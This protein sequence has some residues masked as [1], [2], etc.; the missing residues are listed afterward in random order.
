MASQDNS[1][2]VSI[3]PQNKQRYVTLYPNDFETKS[4]LFSFIENQQVWVTN[5]IKGYTLEFETEK[6]DETG[7]YFLKVK[8]NCAEVLNKDQSNKGVMAY[9]VRLVNDSSGKVE[10]ENIYL[11]DPLTATGRENFYSMLNYISE[12]NDQICYDPSKS[13]IADIGSKKLHHYNYNKST[14]TMIAENQKNIISNLNNAIRNVGELVANLTKSK[15]V[16]KVNAKT[17]I[18]SALN[19]SYDYKDYSIR[20]NLSYDLDDYN[21][22]YAMLYISKKNLRQNIEKSN[23]YA[24]N[25]RSNIEKLKKEYEPEIPQWILEYEAEKNINL[26]VNAKTNEIL[27][28]IDLQLSHT[29]NVLNGL[30]SRPQMCFNPSKSFL[31]NKY[32]NQLFLNLY[33]PFIDTERRM[34]K[35]FRDVIS[36]PLFETS[37]IFEILILVKYIEALEDAGYVSTG[38]EFKDLEGTD[39]IN[40]V[41]FIFHKGSKK[42]LLT[43]NQKASKITNQNDGLI[44]IKV[45][46]NTPDFSLAVVDENDKVTYLMVADAKC[47]PFDDIILFPEDG[48]EGHNTLLDYQMFRYAINTNYLKAKAVDDLV[49]VCPEEDEE[50][51]HVD[52]VYGVTFVNTSLANKFD[53]FYRFL[54]EILMRE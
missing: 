15:R 36:S 4:S 13:K 50:R 18:K 41:E 43:Y 28:S 7:S 11:V 38:I 10:A 26:S 2:V 49:F 40:K 9:K 5:F 8:Y 53:A 23:N 17:I 39:L 24:A 25:I 44:Y 45:K 35:N 47:R 51:K 46:H 20:S 48:N 19:N 30:L 14:A 33:L 3:G 21:S 32:N 1:F 42:I 31:L 37:K 16:K 34:F 29:L 54:L 27:R 52:D 6:E 12:Y 22:L